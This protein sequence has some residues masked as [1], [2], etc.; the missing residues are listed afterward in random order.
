MFNEFITQLCEGCTNP[1][2]YVT[3][4]LLFYILLD[5][6][7]HIIDMLCSIGKR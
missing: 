3:A 7:M 2:E 4:F 6:I 5:A 1:I